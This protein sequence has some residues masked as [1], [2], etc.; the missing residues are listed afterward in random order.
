MNTK[1]KINI[2]VTSLTQIGE[3]KDAIK[4]ELE[5]N[6]ERLEEI[7]D[8]MFHKP[9]EEEMASPTQRAMAFITSSAGLIDGA[10]LGWK[11]YNRFG[12]GIRFFKK[13]K[14]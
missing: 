5:K 8:D 13:K 7:W 1:T 12:K 2:S 3:M 4:A 9:T 10:L 11:L 6:E 14:K